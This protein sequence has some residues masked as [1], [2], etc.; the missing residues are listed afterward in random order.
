MVTDFGKKKKHHRTR[1]A[2][3]GGFV[4]FLVLFGFIFFL[5]ANIRIW[6]K[7]KELNKQVQSLQQTVEQLQQKNQQLQQGIDNSGQ[8]QYIEKVA[9]EQL[10][11]QQ[12]G[13]KVFSF[14][15][16][17]PAPVQQTDN[18]KGWWQKVGDWL[19]GLWR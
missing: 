4:A 8:A 17:P 6:N 14:I 5:V 18:Q 10:D 19:G 13:E 15:V 9:R 16:P 3:V 11:M 7:K 12:P 1:L 2:I